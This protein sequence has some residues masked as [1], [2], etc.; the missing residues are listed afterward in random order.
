M[1]GRN[2]E[3]RAAI[4]L[5]VIV[6]AGPAG[7]GCAL[8][9]RRMLPESLVEIHDA[10]QDAHPLGAEDGT[11]GTGG[12]DARE[13]RG[14]DRARIGESLPPGATARL[15]ALGIDPERLL[16]DQL[17][18]S[19]MSS[20]WESAT[21]GHQDFWTAARGPGHHLDRALFD[22]RLRLLAGE[23][24]IR[25]HAGHRL[26]AAR[27]V[28]GAREDAG[29]DGRGLILEFAASNGSSVRRRRIECDFAI[30]AS[31]VRAALARRLGVA[32]NVLDRLVAISA[33]LPCPPDDCRANGARGLLM[34]AEYGWWHAA[35]MPGGRWHVT[36][37]SDR[38]TIR[39]SDLARP[40]R[41]VRALSEGRW[42]HGRLPDAVRRAA[43]RPRL[44]IRTAPST[45]LSR[46]AGRNWL[47]L[48]DAATSYDPL[49]SAGI[50]KAFE[51]AAQA[52]QALARCRQTGPASPLARYEEEVFAAFRRYVLIRR[53]FYR[54]ALARFPDAPFWRRR[55]KAPT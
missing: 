54:R 13:S 55:V 22:R 4:P 35:P 15:D 46:V 26:V 5:V 14:D 43:R 19:G 29:Q 33:I 23:A 8:A 10:S 1:T 9:L 49:T 24:G 21:V 11:D 45:I 16:A 51:Q 6:G 31:G 25:I 44:V 34:A 20:Q 27:P 18:F 37:V 48:G 47:A 2:D 36:L 3:R 41:W 53:D 42:L 40:E 12:T 28:A 39:G 30:D 17:A 32:R 38:Q 52:A 7:I 50:G